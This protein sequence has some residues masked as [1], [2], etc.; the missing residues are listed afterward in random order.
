M[1]FK[2]VNKIYFQ[3]SEYY[4]G[5][6]LK[7]SSYTYTSISNQ[8]CG[9]MESKHFVSLACIL[10]EKNFTKKYIRIGEREKKMAQIEALFNPLV[11]KLKL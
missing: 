7:K 9:P 5:I 1:E 2:S 4:K 10:Q 6:L 3:N 11:T 8:E